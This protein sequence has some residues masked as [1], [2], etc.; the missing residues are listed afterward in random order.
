[1]PTPA[2]P[3][4]QSPLALD[5]SHLVGLDDAQL[6][7]LCH[8]NDPLKIERDEHGGLH[9]MAPTGSEGSSNE[10][11]VGRQLG[12]WIQSGPHGRGFS[13][14]GGFSLPSG[15]MLA[16]DAAF[17]SAARW[18]AL[19]KEERGGFARIAPDFVIEI[20]SPS[21]S[22]PVLRAKM[23]Q[24]IEDGVRLAWLIDPAT[25]AVT[26]YRPGRAPEML[27]DPQSVAGDDDVLP[28]FQLDLSLVWG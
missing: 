13:S 21:D 16:A 15:R 1:M 10:F 25:R 11:E 27:A 17:V 19:S 2:S 6:L 8:E 9:I 4:S 26:I 24:W 14:S 12:N 23:E 22:R 28:G 5:L 20:Q 18:G 3:P 7:R